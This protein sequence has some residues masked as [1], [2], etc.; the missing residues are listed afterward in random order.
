MRSRA[1][2]VLGAVAVIVLSVAVGL[3][4]SSTVTQQPTGGGTGGAAETTTSPPTLPPETSALS[5]ALD[6]ITGLI[7]DLL[8]IGAL[9]LGAFLVA[10]IFNRLVRLLLARQLVVEN[11]ANSSG[12]DDIGKSLTGL[13][14]LTREEL[15][16][17]LQVVL[18]EVNKNSKGGGA[19]SDH[20][21]RSA[22]LVLEDDDPDAPDVGNA[23]D[24]ALGTLLESLKGIA[25]TGSS[26]SSSS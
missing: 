10:R 9:L 1:F 16:H 14:Q 5:S 18:R 24:E 4:L 7:S 20:V 11:L 12:S 26:G 13:S 21:R 6:G 15:S 3:M 2:T 19:D 8:L 23:L 22:P 25:P 17:Q